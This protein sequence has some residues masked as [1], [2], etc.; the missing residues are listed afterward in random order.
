MPVLRNKVETPESKISLDM[1]R[2]AEIVDETSAATADASPNFEDDKPSMEALNN[3]EMIDETPLIDSFI[4]EGPDNKIEPDVKIVDGLLE[5]DVVEK[6]KKVQEGSEDKRLE[7]ALFLL[8][9]TKDRLNEVIG[10][11]QQ[12][13]S[14]NSKLRAEIESVRRS[15]AEAQDLQISLKNRELELI[16][17]L[18]DLKNKISGLN[19]DYQ[20]LTELHKEAIINASDKSIPKPTIED[21]PPRIKNSK[22]WEPPTHN[23]YKPFSKKYRT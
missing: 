18:T 23:P 10:Q 9:N 20:S 1:L 8:K 4:H 21:Q 22:I 5:N 19:K 11:N 2:N 13:I 14:E 15:Y 6:F 17:Q 16:N 7:E 3:A 12:I